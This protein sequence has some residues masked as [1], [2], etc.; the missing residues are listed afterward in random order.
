MKKKNF[1]TSIGVVVATIAIVITLNSCNKDNFGEDLDL[2]SIAEEYKLIGEK[3]NEGLDFILAELSVNKIEI[4]QT[5]SSNSDVFDIIKDA[6]AS[7]VLATNTYDKLQKDDLLNVINKAPIAII[8]TRSSVN[9]IGV[10]NEKQ[11]QFIEKYMTIIDELDGDIN[12]VI[13]KLMKLQNQVMSSCNSEEAIPLLTAISVG[14]YSLQYWNENLHKW[15]A[16][17]PNGSSTLM[18]NA[19]TRSGSTE[20]NTTQDDWDWFNSALISMGQSDGI[21]AALGAGLGSLAGGIG[22]IPGAIAMGC[23]ASAGAGIKELLT[24]WGVF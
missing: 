5:R 9:N 16:L 8:Q 6:S 13:K 11:M 12:V 7:F 17:N 14:C 10:F 23:N 15:D 22:A 1:F 21:G 24:K 19:R 18:M 4:A 3:H 2:S 20:V